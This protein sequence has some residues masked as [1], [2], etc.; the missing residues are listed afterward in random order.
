MHQLSHSAD[1]GRPAINVAG[2]R[3]AWGAE[4]RLS[5]RASLKKFA[6]SVRFS[7]EGRVQF[8]QLIR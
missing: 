6:L 7:A 8:L 4:G 5:V 3:F 1:A 2:R